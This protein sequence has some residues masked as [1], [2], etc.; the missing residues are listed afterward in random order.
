MLWMLSC[1]FFLQCERNTPGT[2]TPPLVP[3][4]GVWECRD[5]I[6]YIGLGIPFETEHHVLTINETT[7]KYTF[8]GQ[9]IFKD[10][11]LSTDSYQKDGVYTYDDSGVQ[12][13]SDDALVKGLVSGDELILDT[14]DLYRKLHFKK[15]D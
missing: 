5:T 6:K 15:H 2:A 14:D 13:V 3:I 8:E 4:T 9:K 11:I 10:E 1:L 7:F 12:L